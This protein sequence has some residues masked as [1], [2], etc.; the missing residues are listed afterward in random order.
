MTTPLRADRRTLL[1]AATAA[2][3]VWASPVVTS[4]TAHAASTCT[5]LQFN[6]SRVAEAT[7]NPANDG[8]PS[9]AT[10]PSC[11]LGG[12]TG[13]LCTC[14]AWT[15]GVSPPASPGT[16]SGLTYTAPAGCTILAANLRRSDPPQS[17]CLL[18][19]PCITAG[20]TISATGKTVT[21]PGVSSPASN[22]KYRMIL[23]CTT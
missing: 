11:S 12:A 7:S 21:F 18:K 3:V 17:G 23:C 9:C 10:I 16:W 19:W 15:A 2:G 5:Y 8:L 22:W 20:I 14:G 1:K 4:V 6:A 13:S